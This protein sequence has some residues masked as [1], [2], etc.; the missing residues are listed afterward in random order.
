MVG[1]KA[2]TKNKRY[3]VRRCGNPGQGK[4]LQPDGTLGDY[5][6]A[7]RFKNQDL[8]DAAGV[9]AGLGFGFGLWACGEQPE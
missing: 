4:Y 6:T 8:A 9:D 7:K 2:K 1:M 5:R 3:V